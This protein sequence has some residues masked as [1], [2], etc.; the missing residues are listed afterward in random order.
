VKCT[1]SKLAVSFLWA[2]DSDDEYSLTVNL[3][4][5]YHLQSAL[6]VFNNGIF[7]EMLNLLEDFNNLDDEVRFEF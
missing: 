7:G 1:G 4:R 6:N 2:Q 3:R 5:M